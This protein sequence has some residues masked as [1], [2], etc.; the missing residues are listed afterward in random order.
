MT[1]YKAEVVVSTTYAVLDVQAE[2]TK[3]ARK[4][5]EFQVV[6]H[7][8]NLSSVGVMVL[9]TQITTATLTVDEEE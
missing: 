4:L 2:D 1:T 8:Q 5:A 6:R 3:G 7:L 9:D